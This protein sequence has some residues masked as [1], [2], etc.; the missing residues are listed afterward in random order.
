[1]AMLT[2]AQH[3]FLLGVVSF[4]V[5][6][7]NA[8]SAANDKRSVEIIK[9]GYGRWLQQSRRWGMHVLEGRVGL[10]IDY[11]GNYSNIDIKPTSVPLRLF[12][13]K[14]MSLPRWSG[15]KKDPYFVGHQHAL[16]DLFLKGIGAVTG[17]LRVLALPT[18]SEAADLNRVLTATAPRVPLTMF[19]S[20][21]AIRDGKLYFTNTE[22][23]DRY[24]IN[25]VLAQ[26]RSELPRDI[27]SGYSPIAIVSA[28]NESIDVKQDTRIS[29]DIANPGF[30]LIYR[31]GIAGSALMATG[32]L[33]RNRPEN[34][35]R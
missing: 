18:R 9:A 28:C 10:A 16:Q 2:K 27:R 11:V 20:H 34:S 17:G 31:Q 21:G 6:L 33:I 24:E 3:I 23:S 26:Y 15:R 8:A 4:S 29:L 22:D 13:G 14:D 30:D 19:Y 25:A 32:T 35:T 1:M 5:V 12:L 7:P